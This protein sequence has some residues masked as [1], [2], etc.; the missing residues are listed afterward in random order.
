MESTERD[1]ESVA[2]KI[3]QLTQRLLKALEADDLDETGKILQE[4]GETLSTLSAGHLTGK[5]RAILREA[6]RIGL[7]A[8]RLAGE[9]R[10]E[11][12]QKMADSGHMKDGLLGYSR[13][14][15]DLSSGQILDKKR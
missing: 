1:V 4:R 2:K 13:S 14:R 3:L 11:L 15:F 5:A 10:E 9:R 7:E 6:A 12:R 8:N